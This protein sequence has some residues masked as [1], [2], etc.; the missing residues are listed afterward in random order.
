VCS[1]LIRQVVSF[2]IF[3]QQNGRLGELL[4]EYEEFLVDDLTIEKTL[5]FRFVVGKGVNWAA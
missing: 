2:G 1:P 4:E 3:K 5:T